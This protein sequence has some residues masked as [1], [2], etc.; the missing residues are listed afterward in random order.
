MENSISIV[1]MNCR[2]YGDRVKRVDIMN[3]IKEKQFNIAC[4]QY[5]HINDKQVN[6]FKFEWRLEVILSTYSSNARGTAIQFNNNFEYKIHRYN[7]DSM[8]NYIIADISIEE[9]TRFT[10]VNVYGPNEDKREFYRHIKT[11]INAF[12][13]DSILMCGDWN[14]VLDPANILT[15]HKLEKKS[16]Q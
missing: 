16:Y 11:L 9:F 4:L 15:T 10:L 3:R 1:T 7:A 14:M 13:N 12:E 6:K 2:G 8:G 5:I